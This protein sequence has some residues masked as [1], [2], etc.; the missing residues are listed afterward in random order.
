M[1]IE[2]RI[3]DESG[4]KLA[5]FSDPTNI[6]HRIL[7]R[8]TDRTFRC[9]NFVDWYGNTTFNR[10]Q[11]HE[12]REELKRLAAEKRTADETEFIEKL[13]VFAMRCDAEPHLYLKFQ[14]D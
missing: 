1:G 10:Y 14:G 2:V 13:D 9:L 4:N 8:Y 7:P 3:E 12:V 6:L 11:V 5:S